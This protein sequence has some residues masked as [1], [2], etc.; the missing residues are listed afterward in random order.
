MNGTCSTQ[1]EVRNACD[2]LVGKPE[3]KIQ[4]GR[5]RSRWEDDIRMDLRETGLS[6]SIWLRIQTSG[7]L[8]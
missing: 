2:I 5:R 3:G 1:R 7:G 6:G 8:F 4:F